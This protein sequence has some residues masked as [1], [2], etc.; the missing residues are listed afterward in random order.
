MANEQ[1]LWKDRVKIPKQIPHTPSVFLNLSPG[2]K[3]AF[4]E[5]ES[6]TKS[7]IFKI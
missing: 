7:G 2:P 5:F 4:L 1:L 6:G 3:V